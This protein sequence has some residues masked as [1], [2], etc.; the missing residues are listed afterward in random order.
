MQEDLFINALAENPAAIS[1]RAEKLILGSAKG[2][3]VVTCRE[4]ALEQYARLGFCEIRA[5]ENPLPGSFRYWG[6]EDHDQLF[7]SYSQ[8]V[9]SVIWNECRL[10][11]IHIT[12]ENSCGGDHRDWVI[13][14]SVEVADS[15][16]LDV[17]R[18]THAP[19]KAILVFS[20]GRWNRSESLYAATQS[21]TFDNL[22]LS[23]N[24][25][26]TIR[27]D[28]AGFLQSEDKYKRLGIAWRRGALL[29]GPPGNGKTHCVRA[30][31]KDLAVSSLYVQSLSHHYFTA[32]Q[33]WQQVF[34]RARGLRPCVLILEDLDSL[35]TEENRSFFLNQLDGFEQNH[36]LIVLATTNHPDRIDAA[37][38]DRP[39]RF[40][41]KYHFNL[42]S[43][44]ER[45]EYLRSWQE[46]LASETGW[47]SE[48]LER[49]SKACE[50]FSFAYLKELVISSVMKWMHANPSSFGDTMVSQA[51]ILGG[52]MKTEASTQPPRD[53][54]PIEY[55]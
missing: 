39:S 50:G 6:G 2:K 1:L 31:V 38:I 15:F 54:S 55:S 37:I 35:V 27:E 44:K 9:W 36:G 52:Q 24:L 32:E 48:D 43:F 49:I 11:V 46:R 33:M 47:S 22:V 8:V 30:L 3:A 51:A 29:I 41:R 26:S 53:E 7:T 34:D 45:L 14:E 20:G 4:L 18:T 23:D 10:K 40:D 13:A 5:E 19:G 21:A 17:N 28:F 25:K 16:I 12:W 42:P